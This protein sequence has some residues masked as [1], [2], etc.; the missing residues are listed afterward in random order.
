MTQPTY[1]HSSALTIRYTSLSNSLPR[2]NMLR[3][4]S[5]VMTRMVALGLMVTSPVIRPTSENSSSKSRYLLD[6]RKGIK[7][8]FDW[9]KLWW[10]MC[11]WLVGDLEDPLQWRIR[12]QR[13]Y[14]QR[15]GQRPGLIHLSMKSKMNVILKVPFSKH[16]MAFFWK[17]S[18]LKP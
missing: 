2:Y 1:S 12:P 11:R 3:R 5:V 14:Q 9:T 10:E 15:C 13:S 17:G 16:S 8:T 7:N 4:I 6:E 18:N